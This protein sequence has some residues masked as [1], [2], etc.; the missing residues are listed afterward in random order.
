MYTDRSKNKDPHAKNI[1]ITFS[2]FLRIYFT[3]LYDINMMN[4][5]VNTTTFP[6][7]TTIM[8]T[9]TILIHG[10]RNYKKPL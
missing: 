10:P 4:K 1:F 2:W 8:Y 9:D 6:Q 3:F 5:T 7:N